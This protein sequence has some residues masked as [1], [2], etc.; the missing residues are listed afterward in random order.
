[1]NLPAIDWSIDSVV[2]DQYSKEIDETFLETIN[3][4]TLEQ[5][6]DFPTRG[7]KTVEIVLTNILYLINRCTP[8]VGMS[9]HET[10]PLIDIEYHAKRYKPKTKLN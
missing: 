4:C 3:M 2:R 9:D 1:M 6:V 10:T 5:I 8:R 7:S